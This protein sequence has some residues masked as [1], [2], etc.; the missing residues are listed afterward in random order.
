MWNSEKD[1]YLTKEIGTGV[2]TFVKKM[3]KSEDVFDLSEGKLSTSP[4]KRKNEFI[5]EKGT[6]QQRRADFIIYINSDIVIPVEVEKYKNIQEG[7]QQLENYQGDLEKKY[8]ILT[9]GYT[10]QFYNNDLLHH[11]FDLNQIFEDTNF[12]LTYWNEYIKPENYYLT[13]FEESGQLELVKEQRTV[14]KHRKTFFNDITTLI[15]SFKEKL[16][17]EGYFNGIPQ[18]EKEK[19]A[20]EISYA[21]IIQFILYK[22]LVD[23]EFGEFKQKFQSRIELIRNYLELKDY[24]PI[25]NVIGG[26]SEEISKNIYPPFSEEQTFI[27]ETLVKLIYGL[28]NNIWDVSPW[29]DIFLFIKKYN[30]ANIQNEIFGFIYEN[31]LKELYEEKKKGQYFTDPVVANFMLEQMGY[32]P[33]EIKKRYEKDPYSISLID[34]S[35]GSGTFLY[36]GVDAIIKAFGNHPEKQKKVVEDIV[37]NNVFGLDIEEFPLYLVE[38]NILMRMLPLILTE[39]YNDPVEKK[40]KAFLTK[41]SL[42]EFLDTELKNT[43]HD[44]QTSFAPKQTLLPFEGSELDLGYS[45]Y[46]RKESDL[47]DLKESLENR[48]NRKPEDRYRFDFMI[49]NPPYIGYLEAAKQGVL[50]WKLMKQAKVKLSNVYGVNLHSIP[51]NPK[52][53]APPVNMY[54][55]FMALGIALLKDNGRLCYII[56]QNL[57]HSTTLDVLRYHL[58]KFTTIEKIITFSGKMFIGRGIKQNKPIPTSSLIIVLRRKTPYDLHELEIWNYEGNEKDITTVISNLKQGKNTK[59]KNILQGKLLNNVSNWSFIK[60]KKNF[61]DLY[62]T[63]KGVSETIE[64]YYNHNLAEHHFDEIFYFDRGLKFP[65]ESITTVDNLSPA[66]ENS[67]E[68]DYFHTIDTNKEGYY[69]HKESQVVPINSITIPHGSQGLVVFQ[70]PYKIIWRYMNY[71]RFFYTEDNVITNYNYILI[72]SKCKHE[73]MY[74]FALLNSKLIN[75]IIEEKL[76]V[77]SE[78]D[79]LLGITHIKEFLRVPKINQTTKILKKE[80]ISSATNLIEKEHIKL[81][82][83]IDFSGILMQM[84]DT[85]YVKG[86][87]LVLCKGKEETKLPIIQNSLLVEKIINDKYAEDGAINSVQ[88]TDLKSLPVIDIEKQ[89]QLK[90]YIDDLVFA[91]YFNVPIKE[92][93]FEK[94]EQIKGECAKNKFYKTVNKHASKN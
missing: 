28:D 38:M 77:Q 43:I 30:F 36:S 63:Y 24:T 73:I 75:L 18:K 8:G 5:H 57:L 58:S 53:Y 70:K 51:G 3:L 87:E 11:E 79:L 42:S 6:K 52:N 19:R 22:T 81:A 72:S 17:L 16:K 71:T 23:N 13:F 26:I 56:P 29:L 59:K 4:H 74:L 80:V 31:Y 68:R 89:K 46:V 25:L 37:I 76:K 82:D 86:K 66:R 7:K 1:T 92:L 32:T 83:L 78:K 39:R 2:Q 27:S 44:I 69:L 49:G 90:D 14:D 20:V 12:F 35:C 93:G 48:P 60:E 88:L 10:W 41:D 9:D 67:S 55:F 21:Y 40:I 85:I 54:A 34:I 50:F 33:E 45:S 65:K 94:A 47:N 84:F 62:E 91:L 61:S 64:K 15:K